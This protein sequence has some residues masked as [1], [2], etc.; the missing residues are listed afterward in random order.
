MAPR[1]K[2]GG[3]GNRTRR[4]QSRNSKAAQRLW[5]MRQDV[6]VS[7]EYT[8]D[9]NRHPVALEHAELTEVMTA[10]PL[11]SADLRVA[12]LAIVRSL[13]VAEEAVSKTP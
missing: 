5:S 6:G 10:W 8:D 2:N 13:A 4:F 9:P 11:L 1:A 3:G 7:W 12:I